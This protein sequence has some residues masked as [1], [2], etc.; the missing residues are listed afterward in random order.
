MAEK[1]SSVEEPVK[2]DVAL[3]EEVVVD[4]GLSGAL[5]FFQSRGFVDDEDHGNDSEGEIHLERRDEFG[6]SITDPKEAFKQLSW[7][8]HGKKPG[9]KKQEKRLRQLENELKSLKNQ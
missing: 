1:P 4:S 2:R 6:R 5:K 3:V 8:F 9:A 7:R